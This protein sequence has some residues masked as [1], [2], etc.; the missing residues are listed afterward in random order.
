MTRPLTEEELVDMD[1]GDLPLGED[2]ESFDLYSAQNPCDYET[3]QGRPKRRSSLGSPRGV[4][5]LFRFVETIPR[6]NSREGVNANRFS[7]K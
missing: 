1:W 6:K 4:S 7:K 3:G 2:I 5:A